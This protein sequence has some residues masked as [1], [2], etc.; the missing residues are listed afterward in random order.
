[1]RFSLEN[2]S[3]MLKFMFSKKTTKIDE[4]HN[5]SLELKQSK[6][7]P[8]LLCWIISTLV[9]NYV[10]FNPRCWKSWDCPNLILGTR[11][12]WWI[13]PIKQKFDTT[14]AFFI[15][16]MFKTRGK[17]W[18]SLLTIVQPTC[19]WKH[20]QKNSQ[21]CQNWTFWII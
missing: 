19:L 16:K 6:T 21:I 14:A 1:M 3:A 13:V 15:V 18:D 11:K 12:S 5:F 10:F 17:F 8:A 2:R 9:R 7:P 4:I 20:C